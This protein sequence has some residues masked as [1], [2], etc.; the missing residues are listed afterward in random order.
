MK[1]ILLAGG[2]GSRLAPLTA[3][4]SKQLLPV[5]D[6]PLVYYPL[7]TLML[8]GIR[9]I[10]IISTPED[11]PRFRALLGGGD[12]FGLTLSYREQ[13][14]PGGLAQAFLLAE[15]YL[16]AESCAMVLGDNLF[17]GSGL[18]R[19]LRAAAV[20]AEKQARATVFACRVRDPERFGVVSFD[21]CGRAVSLEEKPLQPQSSYAVTGLYLYPPGVSRLARTLR[22]SA[23]GELEI[24]ELNALY[25]ARGLLDVE[26]LGRGYTWLDAGTPESLF[27][28]G[29]FVRMLETRQGLVLSSPE[30]IAYRFG[31][32][33]REAL[34]RSAQRC[35]GTKYGEHLRTLAEEETLRRDKNAARRQV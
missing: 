25:L 33:G 28:A 8:A 4:T 2:S 19:L 5:Y 26:T 21:E 18:S 31:W 13:P 29:A 34:F 24:T 23:R 3:V 27:E 7:S 11:L 30:E 17:Y 22:P 1:G 12:S 6:K 9:D 15:D 16:E 32:I 35:A 10:L 14:S 20:R